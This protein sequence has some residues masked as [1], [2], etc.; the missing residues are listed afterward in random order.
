[1]NKKL[2]LTANPVTGSVFTQLFDIDNNP[3]LDK[4]G[5]AFGFIR[6]E[7][8]GKADLNLSYAGGVR[9]GKSILLPMSCEG[10]NKNKAMYPVNTEFDGQI[11]YT[12]SLVKEDESYRALRVPVTQGSKELRPVTSGG[13]QVYRKTSFD[14]TC[15]L[16][17]TRLVYDKV[18]VQ[19]LAKN[20]AK[21]KG[22]ALVEEPA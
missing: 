7:E 3:R 1:M 6:L 16:E 2:K 18:N 14:S 17:D 15:T 12:D 9:A 8:E 19:P 22:V 10:F 11:V 20:A 4:N 13:Q 21:V 5:A